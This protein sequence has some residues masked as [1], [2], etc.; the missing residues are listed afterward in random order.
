MSTSAAPSSSHLKVTRKLAVRRTAYRRAPVALQGMK[1]RSGIVHLLRP[2]RGFERRENSAQLPC[3]LG[4]QTLRLALGPVVAKRLVPNASDH[5]RKVRARGG[6]VKYRL[7]YFRDPGRGRRDRTSLSRPA[8]QS[9][10]SCS[11]RFGSGVWRSLLQIFEARVAYS[12]LYSLEFRPATVVE[13]LVSDPL[14]SHSVR[15]ALVRISNALDA[16]SARRPLAIEA[17]RCVGRMAAHI[18]NDWPNRDPGDD[19]AT[20]TTLREIR[21]SC[22]RLHDDIEATF[23]DYGIED[24]PGS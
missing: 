9:P 7:T 22:R 23:F 11:I 13:F 4:V 19:A 15:Y 1:V 12:R 16:V 14:L 17:G 6:S 24:S 2:V 8:L 3:P 5:D 20:R 18:D 10:R 21:E